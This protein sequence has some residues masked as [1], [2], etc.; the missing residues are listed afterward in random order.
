M[1]HLLNIFAAT[2]VVS[3]FSLIGI[4]ALSLKEETL[5]RILLI[6]VAF[7]AGSILGAA[8]LDL[9]PEAIELVEESVVFIYIV[10]G[11]VSFFFLERF[12]YWY[13]GHPHEEDI[14]ATFAERESTKGFAYLNLLGDGVHN[15]IDGMIIAASFLV[16]EGGFSVGLATTIAVIFHELPQEMGDYGILIY[17]GFKRSV[18]LLLNFLVALTVVLGGLSAIFFIGAVEALSGF[19]IALSA[20]GFI[21]L[22]A[23]ELIPELHK[24][25]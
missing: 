24:E 17:G 5:H 12:I 7:S 4:Y 1:S 21:Y 10:S 23:S 11:F 25:K 8:Y 2:S 20:G 22:A 9:L 3:L 14:S 19:L 6:L 16:P 15:F 13:H 18:A